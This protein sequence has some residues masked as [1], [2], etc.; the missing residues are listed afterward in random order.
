MPEVT[1]VTPTYRH[2]GFIAQCIQSVLAQT[3]TDW[4]MII[5]DDGSDDKTVQVAEKFLDRRITIIQREHKG[6]YAIGE[7]YALA[8]TSTDSRY[9]AVLEGDDRWPS[10]K[11]SVQVAAL[12]ESAA[13][14]SY[15]RAGL[16]DESGR[17]Y[18]TYRCSAAKHHG[19]NDPVGSVLL[20]LVKLMFITGV[21]VMLRRDELVEAG[22]FIQ[23]DG[24]PYVDHPTWLRLGLRG[25]FCFVPETLG[26]WRRYRRQITTSS[27]TERPN[28]DRGPYL[29]EILDMARPILPAKDW[30]HLRSA[31]VRDG[32]RQFEEAIFS[33]A[34]MALI[35]GEW[36]KASCEL[37]RLL[38]SG[39]GR[40]RPLAL[41]GLAAGVVHR[42]LESLIAAAGRHALPS[43]RHLLRHSPLERE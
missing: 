41:A 8:L 40:M 16:I 28:L 3:F 23:P 7:S 18:A 37:A 15:G 24:I 4:E 34:R 25:P 19:N 1:I 22:G 20:P 39:T 14:L 30:S 42:D 11:L 38:R 29:E 13:V 31:V 36:R 35:D 43:R 6:P 9:V 27:W 32:P 26:Y 21:T 10:T 2:E 33:Q 17:Q 5:V 12:N